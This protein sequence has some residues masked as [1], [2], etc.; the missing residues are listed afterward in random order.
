MKDMHKNANIYKFDKFEENYKKL[1]ALILENKEKIT[2][3]N[4]KKKL[5]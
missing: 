1:R 2:N 5:I 3:A 4:E